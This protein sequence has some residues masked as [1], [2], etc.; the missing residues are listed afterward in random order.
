MNIFQIAFKESWSVLYK[1]SHRSG[2]GSEGSRVQGGVAHLHER[3]P[4]SW[5]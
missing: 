3:M 5:A 4:T 2:D 1:A